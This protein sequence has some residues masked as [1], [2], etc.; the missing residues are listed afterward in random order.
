MEISRY[1]TVTKKL[2]REAVVRSLFFLEEGRRRQLERWL[3]GREE[4]R[5]LRHADAAIVS[6]GKSGRTWL[7]VMISHFFRS[8]YD[9][10]GTALIGFDSLL[11]RHPEIPRIL[12]T[13][14][15]Y[16]SY[17]TGNFNSKADY[18]KLKALIFVRH[19]ADVAV[20]QYFQWK[21]R[22][23]PRKKWLNEYPAHGADVELFEF[24]MNKNAGLPYVVEFLN[25]WSKERSIRSDLKIVRYED[26]RADPSGQ[27][28]RVIR[29]LGLEPTPREI[30]ESVEYGSFENMQKMEKEG[31]FWLSG[32]AMQRKSD[33][34]HESNKVR[35]GKVGG[36][37][38][39]F[40]GTQIDQISTYIEGNLKPGF[41]YLQSETP[42]VRAAS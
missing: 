2:R 20:S 36:W 23:I 38:D 25:G 35:R 29:W 18:R 13:H 40:D 33:D 24:M 15:S 31:V 5:C 41:G 26:M 6:C 10:P 17:Y 11:Y 21:H 27:L 7:R 8:R 34:S 16:L 37:R 30:Q 19:P 4:Y 28:E 12:F 1:Y 14:D 42:L 9:L 22:I 32:R 39:Y 3:R